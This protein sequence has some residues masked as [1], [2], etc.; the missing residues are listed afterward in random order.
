ML[1]TPSN[2]C[3]TRASTHHQVANYPWDG[4]ESLSDKNGP[5]NA[6]PDFAVFKRL[7][8]A[9]ALNNKAMSGVRQ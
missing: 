2:P 9:Y 6:A 8:E 5:V 3:N 7:A 1:L 4:Y